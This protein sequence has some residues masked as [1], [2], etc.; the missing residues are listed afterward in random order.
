M[1][2][3]GNKDADDNFKNEFSEALMVMPMAVKHP[4]ACKT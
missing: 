2:A 3:K 4:P 1:V